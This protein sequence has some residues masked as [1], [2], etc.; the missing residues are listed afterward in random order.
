MITLYG[1][2]KVTK[3]LKKTKAKMFQN[4]NM[5]DC[6]KFSADVICDRKYN[7]TKTYVYCTNLT[8]N[9]SVYKTFNELNHIL[10][11][12]EFAE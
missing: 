8:T 10:R 5:G 7:D 11:C 4:V 2:Y 6:I 1:T 12:F 9:E 3:I